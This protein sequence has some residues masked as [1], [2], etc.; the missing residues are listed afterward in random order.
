M[1]FQF[2]FD[3]R[4]SAFWDVDIVD[5]G[6]SDFAELYGRKSCQND[7]VSRRSDGELL[8]QFV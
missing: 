8:M 7:S 5:S 4:E 2:E 6:F 1:C 3:V